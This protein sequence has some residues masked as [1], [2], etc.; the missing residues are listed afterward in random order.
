MQE[1]IGVVGLGYVG[2]PLALAFAN[3]F[4]N[5]IGFDI[6]EQKVAALRSG[7]DVT[8]EGL[9]DIIKDSSLTVTSQINDL[10]EC[11]VFVVGVPT[12]IDSMHKPDLSPLKKACELLG[13]VIS[14][15]S[16]IVFESTVYPG[17]TEEFCGPILEKTSGLKQSEEFFLGYSPERINPGDKQHTIEKI[18]KI[19]SGENQQVLDRL[20]A[21]YAPIIK[22]GIHK[23]S[24]IKVAEAAKVIENTQRDLNIALMNELAII[25]DKLNISTKDVL[26][27]AGTKWNFLKFYPGLV[28]GHC[29]SVDPYY[30]TT[31]A[32]ELGYHPQV[33][34][35]GRRINDNMGRYVG[36]RLIKLLLKSG[37]SVDELTVGILGLTFKENV[38]DIRNSRIPEIVQELKEFGANVRVYDP[39]A[40]PD[41]AQEEYGIKLADLKEFEGL[42]AVIYAVKHEV[43][44]EFDAERISSMVKQGGAVAD[45]KSVLDS[46]GLRE[47]LVYW[48][49]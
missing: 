41:E 17:V 4:E 47:D 44:S 6:N 29:V 48:S 28:G 38:R 10:R 22:A 13:T 26:D 33:I 34:L 8:N 37:K 19:V 18:T 11:T 2:L 43:F 7:V 40:I 24:S 21:V 25:C 32:Q 27:A 36:Q 20:V 1:R 5:T 16:V 12:P 3:K 31:K 45:L 15:G 30:L 42:D 35:A 46:S 23:A 39:L 9:E 49:L 14:S